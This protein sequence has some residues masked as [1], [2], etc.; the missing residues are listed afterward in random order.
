MT[1]KDRAQRVDVRKRGTR[2]DVRKAGVWEEGSK[3]S[4][5]ERMRGGVRGQGG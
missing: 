2:G 3:G 4:R 5:D 1:S